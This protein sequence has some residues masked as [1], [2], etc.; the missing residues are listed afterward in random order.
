MRFLLTTGFLHQLS[1]VE[2]INILEKM[3]FAYLSLW[4]EFCA[5]RINYKILSFT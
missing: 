2:N 5:L 4:V 1:F 3:D